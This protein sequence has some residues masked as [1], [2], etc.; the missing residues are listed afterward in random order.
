MRNKKSRGLF[1]DQFRLEKLSSQL[2]RVR[3]RRINL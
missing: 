2:A 1:D 3:Q